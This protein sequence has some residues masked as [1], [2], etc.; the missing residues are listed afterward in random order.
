[1]ASLQ[2]ENSLNKQ[3]T[4]ERVIANETVNYGTPMTDALC[5]VETE[6]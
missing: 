3:S 2:Q 5:I 4:F 1:M 6:Y